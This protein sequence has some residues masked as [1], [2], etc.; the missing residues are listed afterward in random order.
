MPVRSP[1]AMMQEVWRCPTAQA[2]ADLK[3]CL[4]F[5]ASPWIALFARLGGADLLL[6][7]RQSVT[8]AQSRGCGEILR[9]PVEQHAAKGWRAVCAGFSASRELARV[10]KCLPI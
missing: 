5:G 3:E 6:Q 2:L 4:D 1:E 10:C 9:K 7:A 8:S